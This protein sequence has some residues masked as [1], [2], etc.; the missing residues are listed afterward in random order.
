MG[1]YQST[2][3]TTVLPGTNDN[4]VKIIRTDL[5]DPFTLRGFERDQV[6]NGLDVCVTHEILPRMLA[7]LDPLT[8]RT[9]QFERDLQGPVLEMRLRGCLVDQSRRAEV[10][11]QFWE[12]LDQLEA[13][14]NRIV[15]D[16]VG[17]TEFNWRSPAHLRKLFYSEL[18]LPT[19]RRGGKVTIDDDAREGLATYPIATQIVAYINAMTDLGKKISVLRTEIDP[20]GRIRTSYGIAGT[21]TGRFSSSISEFGTGGNLQNIEESLRSVLV[22]DPGYKFVKL[23][24][25]SCQSRVVGAIEWNLFGDGRYLDVCESG[26]P[27]TT[28]AKL[29]WPTLGWTGDPLHDRDIADRDFYR[30]YTHR[31]MCKK[32]GH[33]S[34]FGGQPPAIAFETKL[35]VGIIAEFQPKYFAA[36]PAHR[37]RLAWTAEELRTKGYLTSLTGRRR[38]FFGRRS[39]RKVVNEAAAYD[40][41]DTEAYVVNSAMLN[42]WRKN[43]AIFMFQDH[44]ALTFM[45]PEADEDRIVPILQR[46]ILVP[47]PLA[48]GRE[49][50]IPYDCEVGWNKGHYDE[51]TNPD[52]LREYTGH[53]PR[54]RRPKVDFLDRIVRRGNR[55]PSR[56]RDLA[57]VDSDIN[58]SSDAVAE[59]MVTD[60][61]EAVS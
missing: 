20:D 27:H 21:T 4:P 8:S 55:R 30:H 32:I 31:F 19:V 12:T 15:L 61:L 5:T 17:M 26:D 60:E 36:F 22:A 3:T 58:D 7:Q 1:S 50:I 53:D 6:Y 37:Q 23:D 41:Q 13:D 2:I 43:L 18:G 35:P 56:A 45:Y 33:G 42:I 28:V 44:D 54:S 16:G 57:P 10:I 48:N 51:Q 11:D 24:G 52:G 38:Y 47:I 14:L 25:K 59:G 40:P 49:L 34:N 46:E 9:Y 39:D 29:V